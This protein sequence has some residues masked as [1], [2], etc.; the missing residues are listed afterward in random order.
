MAEKMKLEDYIRP[1]LIFVNENFKS[2][3]DMFETIY[4]KAFDLGYVYDTFLDKIIERE[5]NFPTGLQLEK[6]GVAIPHTDAECIKKEFVAIVTT[7]P[8]SFVSM[9]DFNQS[10]AAE[11]AFVLGLKEPHAQLEMLQSLMGLLQNAALL[12]QIRKV[13]S[14]EDLITIVNTNNI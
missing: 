5:K 13:H 7:Q 9:E 6:M 3:K 8:I 10:V 14:A 4:K 2:S 1:E 12:T 11:I